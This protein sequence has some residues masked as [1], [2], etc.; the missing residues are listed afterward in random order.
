M[1]SGEGWMCDIGIFRRPSRGVFGVFSVLCLADGGFYV[2][3]FWSWNFRGL[4]MRR[5]L[6][7]CLDAS[8]GLSPTRE[9]MLTGFVGA[10]VGSRSQQHIKAELPSAR[11]DS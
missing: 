3:C 4:I 5:D 1:G 6:G 10:I 7:F 11:I 8:E 9:L 2:G